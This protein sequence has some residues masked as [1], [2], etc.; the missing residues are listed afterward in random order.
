MKYFGSGLSELHKEFNVLIH[1]KDKLAEAKRV[2]F[3]LHAKLHLSDVSGM[4]QNEVDSLLNDLAPHEYSRMPTSI[5]TQKPFM[6]WTKPFAQHVRIQSSRT[7]K[8]QLALEPI[9]SFHRAIM[10]GICV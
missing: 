6:V 10:L 8:H 5:I 2:F 7:R 9:Q 4:E 3:E 1:K